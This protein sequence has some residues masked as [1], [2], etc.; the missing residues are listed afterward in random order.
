[1]ARAQAP[2]TERWTITDG[3]A[4]I[5]SVT[6]LLIYAHIWYGP[7][8]D[9]GRIEPSF[10]RLVFYP[11]YLLAALLV[12]SHWLRLLKGLALSP[13]LIALFAFA[14]A[15]VFWSIAPDVTA[16]RLV[17]LGFTT[18]GGAALAARWRWPAF[19]EVIAV[20]FALMALLSFF[21]GVLKPDWGRMSELFPGAWRGVWVEKNSLG[22]M[23]ALGALVQIAAAAIIPRRRLLWL[24]AA[25]L[26]IVLVCLSR[27]KTSLL[28]LLLG[29]AGHAFVALAKSGPMRAIGSSWIAVLAGGA[30]GVIILGGWQVLLELLGKD[31]TLTGRTK[32]WTALIRQTEGREGAGFGYGA[33][34]DN[35]DP[36]GPAMHIAREADFLPAHAHSGWL[37]LFI[38]LGLPGVVIFGLCLTQA[39]AGAAWAV[40]ARR[41]GWLLLPFMLDYSMMMITESITLNWHDLWW[42]LFVAV[43]LR[44]VIGDPKAATYPDVRAR[45]QHSVGGRGR[46]LSSP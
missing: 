1:M 43:S 8:T 37:E 28:V 14:T 30:V 18:L 20:T 36:G 29:L 23:M 31:A 25:A 4:F 38:T 35:P 46:R 24:L 5:A 42:V 3:L 9:Y 34:W 22:G 39:W 12:A 27:S 19:V 21:M 26:C 40:Y 17:A 6:M 45:T 44:T 10:I 16:R 41:S 11:A 15:S 7:L 2:Q 33:V 13:F 32:I